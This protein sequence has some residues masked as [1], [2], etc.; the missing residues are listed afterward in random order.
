MV[1]NLTSVRGEKPSV[2]EVLRVRGGSSTTAR[3]FAHYGRSLC[4]PTVHTPLVRLGESP[5]TLIGLKCAR[6]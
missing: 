6:R 1:L 4:S 2:H 3:N 5:G